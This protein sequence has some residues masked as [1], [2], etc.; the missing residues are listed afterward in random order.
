MPPQLAVWVPA[1]IAH[2]VEVLT[3][4]ELW[5]VHWRPS[6]IREWSPPT[7]LDRAFALRVTPLLSSLLDA[8]F[9]ND[10]G[11]GKA[12]L[13]VRLMLHELIPARTSFD[14]L[15]PAAKGRPSRVGTRS[16]LVRT[17]ITETADAP[18]FLPLPTSLVGQRVADLALADHQNRLD[19]GELAARAATSVRTLSRLF[20]A[21][22]GL[23]FKAWRQRAR[24][25]H[26]MDRLARGNAIAKVSV[27]A[28]FA[29]T[30][31]FSCAFRQ[32]T[33]MTPTTFFGRPDTASAPAS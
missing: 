2:R 33:A 29:S 10:T 24:I 25:A 20:P 28:G 4:A 23:T 16:R 5:M 6:A 31:A 21:E 8:A 7:L 19:V 18:T 32:V 9:A 1:G 26:A 15:A 3:D 14:P 12:E 30:A 22:T 11:P 13:L 17:G 27:E